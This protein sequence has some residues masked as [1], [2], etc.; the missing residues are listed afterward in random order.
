MIKLLFRK[1]FSY[2]LEKLSNFSQF[3]TLALFPQL[4]R[5]RILIKNAQFSC[6]EL[7]E[8]KND[9][10]FYSKAFEQNN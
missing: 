4:I 7:E 6:T 5:E 10:N 8:R 2:L 3:L 9:I 1:F